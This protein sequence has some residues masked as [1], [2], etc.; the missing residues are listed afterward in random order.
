MNQNK[1]AFAAG[2]CFLS[3]F[4]L[5]AARPLAEQ[6]GA[7]TAGV[8][9]GIDQSL[10]S[11]KIEPADDFY[12]W[13]NAAWLETTPIPADRSEYGIFSV[14]DDAAKDQIR[15]IIQSAA[16]ENQPDPGSTTQK[17][18]D[19]YRSYTNLE[20]RNAADLDPIRPLLKE[21]QSAKSI[22][23][24]VAVMGRLERAGVSHLFGGYVSVDARK[25]SQYTVYL[26][27]SGLTLPDRDY[28]LSN[29]QRY[30]LLR[31]EL[32]SYAADI[33]R[34]VDHNRPEASAAE[35]LDLETRIAK[36]QW[37]KVEN[38]DPVRTYNKQTADQM[39][40][41]SGFWQAYADATG[42]D[43]S[44]AVVVRQPSFFQ[45]ANTMLGEYPLATWQAYLTFK[46]L[47]SYAPY[48]TEPLEARHFA[49]HATAIT[50][51]DEQKPLW[52]RAVEL[53]GSV[54]GELVG[55]LYVEAHF[56]PAAKQRME[57]LVENLQVAFSARIKDLDWMGEGT[58]RQA[59]EKMSQFTTKIGYPD[60]WKDYSDL[61]IGADLAANILASS[62][63][64][65]QRM[66][67]KLGQPIDRSE[68]HM[69]PQTVNAYYNPTMNEI[70][71]PAAILQPPFFN[72]AADDAV[73]YGAIGAV[74]GH[75]ISH[76]FDDKGSQYDGS[77]ILRNWWTEE[78]RQ[79]FEQRAAGLV[80]QY[81]RY[82]PLEDMHIN[83]ELTLGENIGDL[84]GLSVAYHAYQFSL[85]G[86]PAPVIDGLTG[87]QRFFLGW[88]QIW[89]RLYREPELRRRLL[90]DPHS[91]SQYRVN[92][93][94]CNIDAF[95]E[96][97]DIPEGSPMFIP[98]EQRIRIW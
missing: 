85:A 68:W 84:G 77:G 83:G 11:T 75:E 19:L 5:N 64:E 48:L 37:S 25:S 52:R 66:L 39:L 87:D 8:V 89:R 59:L 79:E 32:V 98:P 81:N 36:A 49:F 46:T 71:F 22:L 12:L 2:I 80:E 15:E 38:R 30:Q 43:R 69:T 29:D 62:R 53:T 16:K 44:D 4:T 9:S 1:S 10:L 88:A 76:G 97:F 72:L 33:L 31:N 90:V 65:H 24:L 23:E 26:T 86:K 74:I 57:Q 7:G 51:V 35:L 67:N 60:Q 58:K 20:A 91:P 54:L 94:V 55:Q 95:Y 56:Q 3:V 61:E 93:I 63:F 41:A 40:A 17:V 47:D 50:G 34:S 13:A 82:A 96:A 21:I 70:V 27:Q 78:D 28:Y 42:F 92:G 73:N 45:Q 6:P 18:G 14:L